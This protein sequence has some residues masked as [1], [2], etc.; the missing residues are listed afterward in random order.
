MKNRPA[1]KATLILATG[2]IAARYLRVPFPALLAISIILAALSSILFLTK[3]SNTLL[4]TF[5]VLALM[6]MGFLRYYQHTDLFPQ[7]HITHHLNFPNP[8]TLRGF[9]IK[10]PIEKPGRVE[11]ILESELLTRQDT[12]FST[13]GKVLISVYQGDPISLHYG[14]EIV[15]TGL[16]QS[17][18]GLRNPGGFDYRAYLGRKNI[19]GILKIERTTQIKSTGRQKGCFFL[20]KIVYPARRFAIR[21]INRTTSGENRSILRALIVGE[22]GVVSPE[23]RDQFARAGVIHVLAV[24]GLHVGFVLL[25]LT[26]IFCLFRIPFPARVILTI[27][28]LI[29]YALLTE[30]KA[31]VVR[32]TTMASIY[33]IG[34]LVEKRTDPF[35]VIGVASLGILFFRPKDLFDVGFQLSFAAVLSIVYFY[36]KLTSLPAV[37]KLSQNLAKNTVGQYIL[38]ILFVSFSAQIG[39]IPLTAVYFNRVP[40]LS[41]ITNI[42]AIP[43]V[44]II[45]A[46]GFTTLI[47]GLISSWLSAVYG[48]LNHELL[49]VFIRAV[50]WVGARPFSHITLPTPDISHIIPYF[51]FLLFLFNLQNPVLRKKFAFLFLIGLNVIAW[52]MALWNGAAKMTWIQF[53]VGQGDAALLHLPRGKTILIDGGEKGPFFDT[54][55][56]VIAPYLRKSGIRKLDVVLLSHPHNDHVGGLI[57]ILKHFRVGEVITAG[58][59]FQ[60]PLFLDFKEIIQKHN[61]PVRTITAPD[62][63]V[64]LPSVRLYFLS[65]TKNRKV[66]DPHRDTNNQSLV[67]RLLFGE[68]RLLFTGDAEKEVESEILL[69]KKILLSD[70][71]K[72]AHH[73][74]NTS[75]TRSFLKNVRP[76]HAII[77]VGEHN[78]FNHPSNSVIKRLETLGASVY[79]TDREGAIIFRSDGKTLNA[80]DWR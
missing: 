69:S 23:V 11:L 7:N 2:I 47:S 27:L 38:T 73:G 46:L 42:F 65:P 59:P 75:S 71:I 57:Y 31:P 30:A 37:L 60:S 34:T 9:L 76:K 53:D 79:R 20:R 35:N 44:G 78:R 55:E 77:S 50:T 63:I 26:T 58:T 4:Q 36:Q 10:D 70:A 29:F 48:A 66:S 74:S 43:L 13:H 33:L 8:I 21:T 64:Q 52:R 54:G 32:A 3:R 39:T 80:I 41:L 25:I 28:G 19:Y 14:E 16:L 49:S 72:V 56:R 67:A 12:V 1:L 18:K 61:I 6:S 51:L 22:K 68:I 24:S 15:I 62:S 40:I 17:P 45:V 5:L